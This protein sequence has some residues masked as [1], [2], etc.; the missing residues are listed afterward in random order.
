MATL[1]CSEGQQILL[2]LPPKPCFF[3]ELKMPDCTLQIQCRLHTNRPHRS[4]SKQKSSEWIRCCFQM[5]GERRRESVNHYPS[6]SCLHLGSLPMS[7]VNLRGW[8]CFQVAG[9]LFPSPRTLSFSG[10]KAIA[11]AGSAMATYL[12]DFGKPF[13]L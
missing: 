8:A 2:E 1:G 4:H 13:D 11:D 12:H 6:I 5:N 7:T 9:T 3:G 10:R